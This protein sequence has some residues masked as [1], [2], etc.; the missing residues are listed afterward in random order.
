MSADANLKHAV[1]EELKWEPSVDPAH[2]GVTVEDGVVTLSG[3]VQNFAQKRAAEFSVR[4]VKGVRAI[5]ENLEVRLVYEANWGDDQIA[6]AAVDRFAHDVSV[7]GTVT[8][9][10][11]K[12][13]VTLRGEVE[14]FYQKTAAEE[15]IRSLAGVTGLDSRITIKPVVD[16]PEVCD[17]IMHALHR[18]WF[19]DPAIIVRADGGKVYLSGTVRTPHEREIAGLTAWAAHGSTAVENDICVS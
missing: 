12:G 4:G 17:A 14:F 10:V 5:A 7:P 2:I 1:L 18:S 9:T 15:A 3:H 13:W 19:F 16:A 8:V 11:Q 6:A